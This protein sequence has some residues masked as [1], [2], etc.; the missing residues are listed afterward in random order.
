MSYGDNSH[1]RQD[2]I[3]RQS[4]R[5]A[6][7]R[8][9]LSISDYAGPFDPNSRSLGGMASESRILTARRKIGSGDHDG[10]IR[11]LRHDLAAAPGSGKAHHALAE[12]LTS[13]GEL[14]DAAA[15][16]NLAFILDDAQS[17]PED[18]DAVSRLPVLQGIFGHDI[19]FAMGRFHALKAASGIVIGHENGEA[20]IRVHRIPAA[21]R[22]LI[23]W[24]LPAQALTILRNLMRGSAMRR[25]AFSETPTSSDSGD[26]D[27]YRLVASLAAARTQP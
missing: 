14:A 21:L 22:G 9:G 7:K 19:Y 18:G 15:E 6:Y 4:V 26:A 2:V 3:N 24:I 11:D 8:L 1:I 13:A 16:N 10:A 25:L 23:Q 20:L 17:C 12:L 27:F 5:H